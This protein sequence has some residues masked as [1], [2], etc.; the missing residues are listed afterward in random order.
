MEQLSKRPREVRWGHFAT[1][2][3]EGGLASVSGT[4]LETNCARLWLDYSTIN[5]S[6]AVQM[7]TEK[8]IRWDH[9]EKNHVF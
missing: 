5:H 6:P 2:G 9:I 3:N 4:G 1:S 7:T 8:E